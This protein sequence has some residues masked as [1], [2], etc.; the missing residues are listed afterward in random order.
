MVMMMLSVENY[1]LLSKLASIF[2]NV[3]LQRMWLLLLQHYDDH[4]LSLL[5]SLYHCLSLV[6]LF[7]TRFVS[8]VIADKNLLKRNERGRRKTEENEAEQNF[9]IFRV[10]KVCS[11]PPFFPLCQSFRLRLCHNSTHLFSL[12]IFDIF[13][14]QHFP[15]R[16]RRRRRR[17]V[18]GKNTFLRFHF[19]FHFS[20][21][22]LASLASF[23][24]LACFFYVLD[25]RLATAFSF[26]MFE[27]YVLFDS[28]RPGYKIR[29]RPLIGSLM[30]ALN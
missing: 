4:L 16:R 21:A 28:F 13:L 11:N 30:S 23:F 14:E 19:I 7:L 1:K 26:Y 8:F 12:L 15:R 10:R 3:F 25:T 17:V 22:F 9:V 29:Y 18:K 20:F 2:G 6:L 5:L 27:L 24:L